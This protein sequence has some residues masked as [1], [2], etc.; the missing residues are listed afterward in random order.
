M[1]NS[2]ST[3]WVIGHKITP[4][5]VSGDY[6]M[7]IGQTPAH[8]PGPPPHYHRDYNEVFLV[9]EGEMEFVVDG[10]VRTVRAGESVDLPPDTF[11]TFSNK[12]DQPCTWIN[13][14]SP[15][16]FYDF[17]KDMGIPENEEDAM[18][19]SVDEAVIRKVMQVAVQYDMHIRV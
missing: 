11:H 12:S 15:K 2:K 5:Q 13:I 17:F 10:E 1:E 18:V 3:R 4:V 6:D 16:G 14:H 19:K 7:V 9:T 8:V